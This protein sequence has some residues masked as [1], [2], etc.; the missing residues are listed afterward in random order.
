MAVEGNFT[1]RVCAELMSCSDPNEGQVFIGGGG[2]LGASPRNILKFCLLFLVP[3]ATSFFRILIYIIFLIVLKHQYRG[4]AEGHSPMFKPGG[5]AWPP[6][7]SVAMFVSS[8]AS[9]H[10]AVM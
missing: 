6:C 10:I 8:L 3:S 2:G 9:K 7:L 1:W 4:G 5:T